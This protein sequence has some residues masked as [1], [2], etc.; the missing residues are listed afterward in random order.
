MLHDLESVQIRTKPVQIQ[1][2]SKPAVSKKKHHFKKDIPFFLM[3]VPGLVV[4]LINNYLPMFGVVIA[5]E[6]FRFSDNMISSFI[7]SKW[8]NF[9]NFK[10]LFQ[11]ADVINATRNTI[12]YNLVFIF[13]D[14]VIPVAL[15]IA[16]NELTNQKGA[17][18]FQSAA[19]LPFF[20]SWIVVAYL[21]LSML[22][23]DDGTINSLLLS[24]HMHKV[25][26][27]FVNG[28]WPYI[29]TFF[30]L[31]KYTGYN[32]VV[33]LATISG[34]STE[35]YEAAAIDGATKPQQ[36]R[37]ITL[38]MLKTVMIIVTL[39]A[40]GR[41]F[42]S[43]FGLFYNVPMNQGQLYDVTQTIDTYVYNAMMNLGN[44]SMTAAAGLYQAV[45]GCITVFVA[46]L[47]VRK[48]DADQALF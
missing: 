44:S 28:A 42:N 38:P 43:D 10:F 22:N 47:I 23:Y 3:L 34:I 17:R 16:L 46:N 12:L 32:I 20:M 39:L 29:L 35:F 27:Y 37:F 36:I 25:N 7:T 5:F 24:L 41:I 21:G 15:A 19:F 4:L 2:K 26:W 40:V 30:H 18:F 33:F 48:I 13:L 6:Q 11:S 45:C 14:L 8:V 31:W 1:P 9:D